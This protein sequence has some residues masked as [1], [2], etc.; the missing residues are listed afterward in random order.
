MRV[1][2]SL[3][4]AAM[5]GC[6]STGVV[7]MNAGTYM[8]AKKSLQAGFGPPLSTKADVYREANEFCDQQD[9]AV[10]TVDLQVLN[11]IFGRPGSV[12]LEFRC[13][14]EPVSAPAD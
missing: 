13:V 9:K 3:V 11:S 6:S 7:P 10:E 2:T 1:C 14:D 8:I 12:S 5:V 4:V